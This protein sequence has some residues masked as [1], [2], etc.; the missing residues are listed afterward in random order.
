[1]ASG[2]DPDAV[3][4]FDLD[5]DGE[6]SSDD[7][8]ASLTIAPDVGSLA[9]RSNFGQAIDVGGDIMVVSSPYATFPWKVKPS[10]CMKS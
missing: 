10:T 5:D 8:L 2:D 1:M 3:A 7:N 6:D 4:V 9:D